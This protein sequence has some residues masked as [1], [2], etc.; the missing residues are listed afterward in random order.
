MKEQSSANLGL[1]ALPACD[2]A[3]AAEKISGIKM[4]SFFFTGQLKVI[5][6]HSQENTFL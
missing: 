3:R 5:D 1:E 4:H 2:V 6:Y